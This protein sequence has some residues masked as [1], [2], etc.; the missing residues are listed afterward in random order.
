MKKI[1]FF[2]LLVFCIPFSILGINGTGTFGSPY[3]GPLTE[4]MTW[5][6]PVYING[7]VTVNGFT[8]NILPGSRIIFLASAND[9][10]ISG[11]GVL[12]ASGSN[13]NMI[14]FTA[15]Y[16][17]NGIYGETGE[18][19]GHLSF[20]SMTIGFSTPS[21]VNYCI[22]EYGQKNSNVLNVESSGGGLYTEYSNL[23][24]SNSIF[25]NNF[26]GWGGGI[27]VKQSSP[28]IMNCTIANNIAGTTGGGMLFYIDCPSVVENCVINNNTSLGGGGAGGVFAGFNVGN[29]LFYN[30]VIASNIST[31][32]AGNNIR[33][34]EN[35]AAPY[36]KFQNCIVWGTNNWIQY[37]YSPIIASNFTNC[38]LQGGATSYTNCINLNALNNDPAGPNFYN[39]TSGSEDFEIKVISPCRDAGLLSGAPLTDY[40]GNGRIG[41]VDIGAFEV[42]FC[43]WNGSTSNI[44]GTPSNWDGNLDPNS[45]S[46]DVIIPSGLTN[47]P[48]GDPSAGYVIPLN[49]TL[50]LYPGAKATFTSLRN[51]GSLILQSDATGISSLILNTNV[52]AT[53]DLFLTGGN[54]GAPL[55]KLNKWHFISAPVSSLPVSVFAPAHTQNVAGWYDDQVSGTLATGWV[56]YDG[57]RYSTGGMG[58]PTFSSLTPGIGYDYYAT[59]DLKYTFT[60]TLNYSDVTIPLAYTVADVLHGYNLLGNPFSSGLNWDDIANGVYFPFPAGTSKSLYFTRDNAQCAYVNGI[61]IPADVNGI[62]PPMQ[63]FFIKTA[64]PGNS[65]TIPAGAR[66]QT[67]I[68][69]RYKKSME[70]IPLVRLTL[71]ENT[72][73]D[74]TVLRFDESATTGFDNDFDAPKMFLSGDLLSIYSS[75]GGLNY[76]INGQPFPNPIVEIPVIVN[77]T[78]SGNH[79]ISATQLE[80]LDN[81]HVTL[82]DNSTGFIADLKTTPQVTFSGNVGTSADRFVLKVSTII[83]EIEEHLISKGVFNIYHGNN[84]INIQTVSDLWDGKSGSVKIIELTG[85][86]I[87]S[88]DHA[89]FS[90]NSLIQISA[91]VKSG[92][93]IVELKSGVIRHLGKVIIK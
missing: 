43:R 44:W 7:D 30:C 78:T 23:S 39:V 45:G 60:G 55:L 75:L 34:Y 25:R 2:L 81:Y 54:P 48:T 8:L 63:G 24:I 67:N 65:L 89:M 76:A 51:N 29:L 74:E 5:S 87:G 37:I 9:L 33:L 69:A 16:N 38:A 90:K 93:Y 92:I 36:P 86:T 53:V 68:H 58:G 84:L 26:A 50:I 32:N 21:I 20:Q 70:V 13:G 57:Y 56:A 19:W 14:R 10:I 1:L 73:T 72:L 46:F 18:R 40:L 71:S 47:Y 12:N 3:N 62:I 4:D 91:P 31:A 64:S 17:N 80:G 66:V 52:T 15:D 85:R 27:L 79:T 61:G 83:T 49:K 22:I 77:L 6:G 35:T 82:T 28:H 11:S 42:Q 59:T 41:P 88:L